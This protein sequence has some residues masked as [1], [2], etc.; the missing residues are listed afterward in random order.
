MR[1]GIIGAMEEEVS[2]FIEAMVIN[3]KE[4]KAAMTFY[5]GV[6][7]GKDVVVVRSGIGKVNMAACTQILIDDFHVNAVINTGIAGGLL[8]DIQVG[9][10]VISDEAMHHDVDA[11]EF[12]YKLGMIPQMDCSI[13]KADQHLMDITKEVCKEVNPDIGCFTGRV[14][15]GDQFI[16]D[17]ET[18]HYIIDNFDGACTEMEGAAM[19]QVA[20]LNEIPFLIVRA[21]SDKA[22]DEATV[23]YEEFESAAIKHMVRLVLGVLDKL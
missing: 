16:S 8:K 4:F 5:E 23:S 20:Y 7:Q 22:D 21:I 6:L 10:I 13:F 11:T 15:S 14:V 17:N 1:L 18:K 2:T 19:A 12:G 9:D 3:K